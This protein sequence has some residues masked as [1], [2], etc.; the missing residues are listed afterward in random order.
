MTSY[1]PRD[2]ERRQQENQTQARRE[3]ERREQRRREE[4]RRGN[5]LSEKGTENHRLP[6][7]QP[8]AGDC[9]GVAP[10]AL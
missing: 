1:V 8:D 4:T 2:G 7:S 6:N 10:Q 9:K 5:P 3:Q